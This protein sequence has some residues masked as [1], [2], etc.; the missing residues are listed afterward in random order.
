M[1]WVHCTKKD[2]FVLFS[3]ILILLPT[4]L[5]PAAE[6]SPAPEEGWKKQVI[7]DLSVSQ[8]EFDNWSQGGEDTLSWQGGFHSKFTRDSSRRKWENSLDLTYGRTRIEGNPSR[9]T[10]DELKAESVLSFKTR[11]FLEPFVSASGRTQMTAG[12]VVVEGVDVE[13]S[14]FL[15]P[16]YFQE[17]AG[18][19]YS[20]GES[21]T[22]RLG[23]ALKQTVTSDYPAWADDPSTPGVEKTRSEAGASSVTEFKQKLGGNSLFTSKLDLFSNLKAAD[24]VDVRWDNVLST[25]VT[26]LLTFGAELDLVYDHDISRSRQIKQ[27]LS[28]GFSYTLL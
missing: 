28:F 5:L 6:P 11:G 24:Q 12:I 8:A 18:L 23:A 7:A 13:T 1:G 9:K 25:K 22:T 2:R 19:G 17:S 15:D 4:V 3:V 10:T 14:N 27:L 21:F 16:G 20:K 26:K